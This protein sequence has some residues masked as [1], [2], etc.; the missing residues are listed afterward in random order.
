[1]LTNPPAAF[2]VQSV[3][4]RSNS[5][6][7]KTV[8]ARCSSGRMGTAAPVDPDVD[9]DVA[10]PLA[11]RGAIRLPEAFTISYDC[12]AHSPTNASCHCVNGVWATTVVLP[13]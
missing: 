6:R 3:C 2:A 8:H 1:M 12:S 13:R 9:D 7:E 11:E 4:A 10:L 5:G